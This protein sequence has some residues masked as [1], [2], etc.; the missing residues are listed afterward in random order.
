MALFNRRR[1]E[2]VP[3]P[4]ETPNTIYA[5]I[6]WIL[7]DWDRIFR[8]VA[9]VGFSVLCAAAGIIIVMMAEAGIHGIKLRHLLGA[10]IFVGGSALTPAII[11]IWRAVR[12]KKVQQA[13]AKKP[14]ATH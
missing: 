12:K 9:A 10:G 2:P 1:S 4:P 5:L 3:A 14:P 13:S 11:A 7:E 6:A 8:F